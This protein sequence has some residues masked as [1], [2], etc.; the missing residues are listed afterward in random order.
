MTPTKQ[1]TVCLLTSQTQ[2]NSNVERLIARIV[3]Y[4]DADIIKVSQLL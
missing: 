3:K 1:V 2:Q 4:S